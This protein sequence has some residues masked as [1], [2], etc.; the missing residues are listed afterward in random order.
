MRSSSKGLSVIDGAYSEFLYVSV[1]IILILSLIL[2]CVFY[3]GLIRSQRL[4][5]SSP[6]GISAVDDAYCELLCVS[7]AIDAVYSATLLL[8]FCIS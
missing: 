1:A 7:V 2:F 8:R 3:L 4:S 5:W 6:G